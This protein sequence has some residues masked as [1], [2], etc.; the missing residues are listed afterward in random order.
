MTHP[1]QGKSERYRAISWW[2]TWDD[3]RWPD[4]DVEEKI[5]RRADAAA[6]AK[7][8]LAIIFGAHCRWDFMPMWDRLHDLMATIA[9]TL[10][11]RDI[12]LFDHHS[13]VAVER[14]RTA[15]ERWKLWEQHRHHL[16][17]YPSIAEAAD[18]KYASQPMNEWR[19]IDV[20]TGDPMFISRYLI[21]EFC[22]NNEDYRRAYQSYVQRLVSDT[23]IDGLMSDDGIFYGGWN[24]CGCHWCRKKFREQ[25][26]HELPTVDDR[27]FWGN[28][29]NEAFKDWITMRFQ[30]TSENLGS[31]QAALPVGFPLMTCCSSSDSQSAP[32]TGLTYQEF[33]KSSN[34]VMLEMAG[35]SP[36]MDGTWD[37]RIASQ[38]LHYDIA[39][40]A[41]STCFGLGYGFFPDTAF[42]IWVLNKFLGSDTWFSTLKG[43]LKLPSSELGFLADD[44]E[45]V[46][47]GFRWEADHPEL[48]GGSPD[49]RIAVLF[50]RNTRDYYGR[51]YDDYVHEYHEAC[52]QLMTRGYTF[53]VIT[54]LDHAAEYRLLVLS[55]VVCLSATEQAS[56]DTY[57][58]EGGAVL[59]AGPLGIRGGRGRQTDA[60][61]SSKYGLIYDVEER[62]MMSGFPPFQ[63]DVGKASVAIIRAE[64]MSSGLTDVSDDGSGCFGLKT[65]RG[66]LYARAARLTAEPLEKE[67]LDL[68]E[69][70]DGENRKISVQHLPK[71]WYIRIFVDGNRLLL[72]GVPGTVGTVANERLRGCYNWTN[73]DVIEQIVYSPLSSGDLVL[74]ALEKPERITVHSPDLSA[75]RKIRGEDGASI[76]V[77]LSGIRRYFI[78]EIGFEET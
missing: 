20:E 63:D 30:S 14:P 62:E 34:M 60:C 52:R 70:K 47:E 26:G 31:V 58:H 23:G 13:S 29:E 46:G 43:R 68:I 28:L 72:H 59:S 16:L 56:L 7:V 18:W 78:V 44:P 15:D 54:D 1:K 67:S 41:K 12:L 61:W 73:Q 74:S 6:A 49:S 9:R 19:M 66:S 57:L 45:L 48:F 75:P 11:D 35:S 10:H 71:G 39:R 5:K 64:G 36:D 4:R 42:F 32:V 53:D 27:S 21:E 55:S 33:I 25:Y 37:G 8:N 50:S 51:T 77:D 3:L 24:A 2:L 40:R 65:D 22:I 17:Y 69:A 38:L 76:Q